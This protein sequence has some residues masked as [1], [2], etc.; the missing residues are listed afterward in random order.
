MGQIQLLMGSPNGPSLMVWKILLSR[1]GRNDLKVM[2]VLDIFSLLCLAAQKYE[3]L[4]KC[5]IQVV[6]T[7]IVDY[8]WLLIF[9]LF[10][11]YSHIGFFLRVK[12]CF[13]SF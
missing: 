8:V 9:Q 6:F 5:K 1:R 7:G 10:L 11:K 2:I 3:E 13:L 12:K 4:S